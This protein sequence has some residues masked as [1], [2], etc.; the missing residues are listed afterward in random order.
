MQFQEEQKGYFQLIAYSIIA[1]SVGIIVR[2]TENLSPL[3]ITFFRAAIGSLAILLFIIFTRSTSELKP[4]EVKKTLLAGILQGLSIAVYFMAVLKTSVAN[5]MFLLYTAPIFSVFFAKLFFKEKIQKLTIIGLISAI[6]GIVLIINPTKFTDFSTNTIGNL[7]GLASG[8]LYAAMGMATKSLRQKASAKY[9]VFWQYFIIAVMYIFTLKTVSISTV[10][11]NL[12]QLLYL[13]IIACGI[14]FSLFVK[15]VKH[16][17]AQKIYIITSLQP[18]IGTALAA[19]IFKEI[20]SILGIFGA[21]FILAGI[22]IVTRT[23]NISH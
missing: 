20:P 11:T 4:K 10:K 7:C 16:V 22:L 6:I 13:G 8:F 2:L 17:P 1:G 23:Q 9:T 5:A 12:W 15:G 21:I 14:Q 18:L 3:G 19:L